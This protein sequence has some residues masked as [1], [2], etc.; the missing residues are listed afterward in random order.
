MSFILGIRSNIS[1][2]RLYDR[3]LGLVQIY[4]V[5]VFQL[6]VDM[7]PLIWN[8]IS[9]ILFYFYAIKL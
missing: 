3:Y 4:E 7:L 5:F 6:V 1:T 8:T 2:Q 9:Q